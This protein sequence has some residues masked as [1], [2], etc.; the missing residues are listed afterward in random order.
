[1]IIDLSVQQ[2]YITF[3]F[4]HSLDFDVV[5]IKSVNEKTAISDGSNYFFIKAHFLSYEERH[6]SFKTRLTGTKYTPSVD[7]KNLINNLI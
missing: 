6:H 7:I 2:I 4:A 3:W 5:Q 1:M